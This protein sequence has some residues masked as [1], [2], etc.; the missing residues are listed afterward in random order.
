MAIISFNAAEVQPNQHDLIPA[1]VYE[2]VITNSKTQAI[3][4]G[5]GVGINITFEI[6]SG[7]HRS[8]KVWQWINYQHTNQ[9]AQRIG[10]GELSAICHAVGVLQLQDTAQLHNLPLLITVAV[11]RKDPSRNVITRFAPKTPTAAAS[12][13]VQQPAAPAVS[14]TP[15]AQTTG[16]APWAR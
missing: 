3:K 14:A 10:R 7:E 12:V 8:R 6:I 1:G 16:A 4:S 9:E 2:A 13:P 11:D 5:A 15:T